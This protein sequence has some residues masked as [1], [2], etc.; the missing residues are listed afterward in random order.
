MLRGSLEDP[1]VPLEVHLRAAAPGADLR[2]AERILGA[3]LRH[4][5]ARN[6]I[7]IDAR[8][9]P[10]R[11]RSSRP[12]LAEHLERRAVDAIAR[13]STG[14][15]LARKVRG[16]LRDGLR[17]GSPTA[18]QTAK[19]LRTSVRTLSRRLREQGTS[20]GALLDEVRAELAG[21]YLRDPELGGADVASLLGFS[22]ATAFHRAFRR[23]FR[24]TPAE[25]RA[26][27]KDS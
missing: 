24:C 1:S 19:Q 25:L 18:E 27:A 17:R 4:G 14:A 11:L 22:D 12:A 9:L 16:V 10:A 5:A 6:G 7:A 8:H 2:E 15:S 3:T 20:H 21:R 13:L 26:R 23:W